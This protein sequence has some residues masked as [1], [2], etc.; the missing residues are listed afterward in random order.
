M[1]SR[2]RAAS[3]GYYL[4]AVWMA[5][6]AIIDFV[7][8]HVASPPWSQDLAA[9]ATQP[10]AEPLV[11]IFVRFIGGLLVGI[12]LTTFFLVAGPLRRSESWARWPLAALSLGFLIPQLIAWFRLGFPTPLLAVPCALALIAIMSTFLAVSPAAERPVREAAG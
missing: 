8:D 3:A 12:A 1:T 11:F 6:T 2:I 4:V 7:V 10:G 9:V 5:V